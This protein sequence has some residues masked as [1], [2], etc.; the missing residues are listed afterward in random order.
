MRD[1][2]YYEKKLQ[3]AQ[4]AQKS[5]RYRGY[6]EHEMETPTSPRTGPI[7]LPDINAKKKPQTL[8]AGKP[9]R[10]TEEPKNAGNSDE[11]M[12]QGQE[13]LVQK[14][15]SHAIAARQR[16]QQKTSTEK[17]RMEQ[18]QTAMKSYLNQYGKEKAYRNSV[19]QLER[20]KDM[21]ML[22]TYNPFGKPGGGAPLKTKSGRDLPKMKADFDIRF[23]DDDYHK[24]MVDSKR[25]RNVSNVQNDYKHVLDKQVG[26]KQNI[27][28]EQR[29]VERYE[30]E[31]S[32]RYNP[33]GKPGSG[34]P[35]F[36][37]KHG[38]SRHWSK[39]EPAAS[40]TLME[41][42]RNRL[43]IQQQEN[44]KQADIIRE[45]KKSPRLAHSKKAADPVYNPWGRGSGNPRYD[46]Q[47]NVNV[48]FGMKTHYDIFNRSPL[49]T[50]HSG[51]TL[52][53]W[54]LPTNE[55][56]DQ[57]L[58]SPHEQPGGPSSR[59]K[60]F[61]AKRHGETFVTEQ[62]SINN[63]PL[64]N[65]K[66]AA[67]TDAGSKP[68][69]EIL[70]RQGALTK[71]QNQS[72]AGPFHKTDHPEV[73][74]GREVERHNESSAGTL[75]RELENDNKILNLKVNNA[76]EMLR[77]PRKESAKNGDNQTNHHAQ[78]SGISKKGSNV[79]FSN[80]NQVKTI[81]SPRSAPAGVQNSSNDV[82]DWMRS[83]AVCQP[84]RDVI[85]GLIRPTRRITSDVTRHRLDLRSHA[86][87]HNYHEELSRQ[88][89]ERRMRENYMKEQERKQESNW[90]RNLF[91][92]FG[93]PGAG[94]PSDKGVIRRQFSNPSLMP[95]I[96]AGTH[97]PSSNDYDGNNI[98]S[99]IGGA[100]HGAPHGKG[101]HRRI[102]SNAALVPASQLGTG[103]PKIVGD[104]PT[105]VGSLLNT[106]N[107]E[108]PYRC[109][110]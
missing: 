40:K 46:D 14:P 76:A 74:N 36:H 108:K 75:K 99:H 18:E 96:Q 17:I 19:S 43:Q 34:A 28:D 2:R 67:I 82:A 50:T 49:I 65:G 20:K 86:N 29:Q 94:A 70:K 38:T 73:V 30:E 11:L 90:D 69:S 44:Q 87:A 8:Q 68:R 95:Q 16:V 105:T 109:R 37:E 80:N 52:G 77:S 6:V 85:S 93:R 23:R 72:F 48:R 47:G 25:Y 53:G 54:P 32:M 57:S 106:E 10:P 13:S 100:G 64:L 104:K 1:E 78:D 60:G 31:E 22:K 66:E 84:E 24:K 83:K 15:E 45:N 4:S 97:V 56:G 55:S 102:F 59:R 103:I 27:Q 41:T 26:E 61:L 7:G 5:P 98:N 3:L 12:Y 42:K 107:L 58:H 89:A 39:L 63:P 88:V 71:I 79:T 92:N 35:R 21:E 51:A 101:T 9:V 62:S 91:T 110:K 81:T 33:Y